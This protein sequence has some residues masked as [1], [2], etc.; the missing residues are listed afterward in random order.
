MEDVKLPSLPDGP[1]LPDSK[2]AGDATS[3][4]GNDSAAIERLTVA[5]E[6]IKQ[7]QADVVRLLEQ[8]KNVLE[9]ME[10][11]SGEVEVSLG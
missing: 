5:V 2:G 7:N 8:I 11:S 10:N 3:S 9:R 4:G 1:L 6:E